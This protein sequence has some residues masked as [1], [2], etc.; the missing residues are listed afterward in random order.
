MKIITCFKVVPDD[1]DI[2]IND[3]QSLCLDKAPASISSYDL[4][5][6]EAGVALLEALDNP[7]GSDF[8][9]MSHE[10]RR[11]LI[12]LS[13]G[14]TWI[15]DS[16]LK[17]NVLS[18]GPDSLVLVADDNL[19][20]LDS[21]ATASALRDAI[22]HIGDFD[23]VICGEG[24]AD[25]YAQQVGIQLG[26]LFDLP[27]LNCV[28]GLEFVNGSLRAQRMLE[29]NV[30]V[31]EVPLP[32]VISV[33]SDINKPRIAG[34]KQILAAGKKPVKVFTG[35]DIGYE[36]KATTES[37]SVLAPPEAER[38]RHII[39]GDSEEDIANFAEFL[40]EALR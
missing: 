22:E 15:D 19:G 13:V 8:G 21:Y 40:A 23:L 5:A 4:N 34:M 6:I 20:D 11:E 28:S 38:I 17:K 2:T 29:Y 32:A 36:V 33:T 30:Q 14:G 24:S 26:A 12:A 37:L 39:D 31:I 25:R 35:A 9:D 1:Q 10:A 18:R 7:D 3:N 16:K 27:V